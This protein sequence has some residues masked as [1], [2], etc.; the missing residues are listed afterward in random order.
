MMLLLF[1]LAN[2]GYHHRHRLPLNHSKHF[3]LRDILC[4]F[5]AAD[6]VV[7]AAVV[8]LMDY[9]PMNYENHCED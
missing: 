8:V 2:L 1:Y 7:V 4:V 9:L 3:H 6:D 5:L